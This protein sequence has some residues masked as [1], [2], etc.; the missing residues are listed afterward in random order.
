MLDQSFTP[1]IHRSVMRS[2]AKWNYD[3][4]QGIL[5]GK[6]QSYDDID[7]H[8][9]PDKYSFDEMKEDCVVMNEIA[10]KRRKWR[11]DTGSI[12]VENPEYY[13]SL[14][15][16]NQPKEF[17]ESKKIDSKE[18]IEEYMLIANMLVAEYLVKFCK[19]K[20]VLRTQ[21]P[22]KEEKVENMM[23][24]FIKVK[25]DVDIT[26]SLTTQQSFQKLKYGDNIALY[27]CCMRKYF[28]N[29]RE[30]NYVTRGDLEPEEARHYSLNFD[31]YTHFTSPIRRYPD[32]L[33]HRQLTLALE[34]A[35]NTRQ[36]IENIDYAG[37]ASYCS[38][39]YL[40]AKYASTT[41]TKLYHCIF[42]KKTQVK[43][44]ISSYCYD[45]NDKNLNFYLPSINMTYKYSLRSD[46]RVSS[47][48][49]I[50]DYTLYI[51]FKE[52]FE[53]DQSLL[54]PPEDEPEELKPVEQATEDTN[55]ESKQDKPADQI[56]TADQ[57]MKNADIEL[58]NSGYDFRDI[59]SDKEF[60]LLKDRIEQDEKM[61]HRLMKISILDTV[62]LVVGTTDEIPIDIKCLIYRS[63]KDY[64]RVREIKEVEPAEET[65]KRTKHKRKFK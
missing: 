44:T 14:D 60:Y 8:L 9:V 21:L 43:S 4:V 34:H 61:K 39:R 46:P 23:E 24:Y 50:D 26:S 16:N 58:K 47:S 27:Y 15:E 45:I 6:I 49:C 28:S 2:C 12:S 29:I 41:C 40:T 5:D 30:A 37:Y 54:A 17:T 31:L 32:L 22:P 10:H 13:F 59:K 7:P 20:A 53:I 62:N 19:D 38:D 55:E 36:V 63:D 51:L 65:N 48:Y 33:V 42:L 1:R 3:L 52:E 18:L 25:A 11:F 57:M 56:P 64:D 35:E